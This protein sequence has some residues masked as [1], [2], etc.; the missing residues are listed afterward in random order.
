MGSRQEGRDPTCK[1]R[2]E[3]W[4]GRQWGTAEWSNEGR[5]PGPESKGG[6]EARSCECC[7]G[8]SVEKG[9]PEAEERWRGRGDDANRLPDIFWPGIWESGRGACAKQ[10]N[11]GICRGTCGAGR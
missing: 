6:E 11:R 5:C 4:A 2:N 10:G 1:C 3:L 7:L 8:D 9:A